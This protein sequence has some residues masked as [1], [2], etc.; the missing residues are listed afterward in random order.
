MA[1]ASYTLLFLLFLTFSGLVLSETCVYSISIKT[2]SKRAAGTNAKV[3]LKL[4]NM[5]DS[6][7]NIQNLEKYGIMESGHDYFENNQ[8]DFFNYAGRCLTIPVCY[9]KLSHDNGGYKP[10]WYVNYVEIKTAGGAITPTIKRFDVNQWLADDEPPYR[11]FTSR[12][13]CVGKKKTSGG[14]ESV[15]KDAI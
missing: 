14:I 1:A 3:S 9:I 11:T 12:D 13:L 15:V 4:S 8:L 7:I 6:A 2:G 10:G 5:Q